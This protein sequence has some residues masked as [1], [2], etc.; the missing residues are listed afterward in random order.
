MIMESNCHIA[1]ILPPSSIAAPGNRSR[2]LFRVGRRN[3]TVNS[4]AVKPEY[5]SPIANRGGAPQLQKHL[6]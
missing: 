6:E 3:E 1:F 4:A 2:K 5:V